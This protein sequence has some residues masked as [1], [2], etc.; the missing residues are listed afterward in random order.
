MLVILFMMLLTEGVFAALFIEHTTIREVCCDNK[1]GVPF[2]NVRSSVSY[3]VMI[4]SWN[5]WGDIVRV[6]AEQDTWWPVISLFIFILFV[7]LAL[8]NAVIGIMCQAAIQLSN[9]D[10]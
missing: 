3:L 5:R 8:M 4:G 6:V 9:Q 2:S 1:F 7:P 10:W